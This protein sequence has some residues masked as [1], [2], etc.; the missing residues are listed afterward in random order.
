M[1]V[2]I[3]SSLRVSRR[4]PLLQTLKTSVAVILGWIFS[5][6][7]LPGELPIFAAMAPIFVV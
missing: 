2:R 5:Q 4:I 3:T 6:C 7:I 1:T